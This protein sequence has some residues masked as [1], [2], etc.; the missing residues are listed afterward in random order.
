M[1]ARLTSIRLDTSLADEAA[2]LLGVKSRTEAVHAA[3]R[4][5]VALKRFQKLMRKNRGK[6]PFAALDE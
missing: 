5:I 3:L 6:L 4:E 2:R 1:A